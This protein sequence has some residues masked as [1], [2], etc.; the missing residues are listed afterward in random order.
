MTRMLI[1]VVGAIAL[2]GCSAE[3]LRTAEDAAAVDVKQARNAI[4]AELDGDIAASKKALADLRAEL[5]EL[6]HEAAGL[7]R[8]AIEEADSAL[9][10][11]KDEWSRATDATEDAWEELRGETA[12]VTAK[13]DR[14]AKRVAALTGDVKDDF[15]READ[16]VLD[17]IGEDVRLLE[18][19]LADLDHEGRTEAEKLAAAFKDDYQKVEARLK[20]ARDAADESWKDVRHDVNRDLLRLRS[21]V[22]EAHDK[23]LYG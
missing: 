12:E 9:D 2:I 20:D 14:A 15:V 18:A 13:V 3:D 8:D 16:A 21:Q 6:D 4:A 17:E 1:A 7:Y 10:A 19:E 11:A 5:A 23:L 22:R